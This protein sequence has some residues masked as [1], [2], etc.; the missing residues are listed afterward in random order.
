MKDKHAKE[1]GADRWGLFMTVR[2]AREALGIS[3]HK[4]AELIAAG[5]LATQEDPLDKRRKLI[6]TADVVK[7]S[8]RSRGK[9][10]A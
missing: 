9:E 3:N 6:L 10:A 4:I 5:T 2:E 1:T 7:L 8:A